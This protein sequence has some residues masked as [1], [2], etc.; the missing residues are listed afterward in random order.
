M[1]GIKP[2]IEELNTED[3]KFRIVHDVKI[4][5]QSSARLHD[6]KTDEIM[7]LCNKIR[8][9]RHEKFPDIWE[10]HDTMFDSSLLTATLNAV[11]RD[12]EEMEIQ[13]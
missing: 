13:K 12:Y 6:S 5:L 10:I 11:I 7:E 4:F 2:L 9:I 1:T 3:G 8:Q